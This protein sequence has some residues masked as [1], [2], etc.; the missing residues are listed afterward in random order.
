MFDLNLTGF[1]GD[2]MGLFHNGPG[3][4]ATKRPSSLSSVASLNSPVYAAVPVKDAKV[5]DKFLRRVGRRP[6]PP[7]PPARGRRLLPLE[8][9]FYKVPLPGSDQRIRCYGVS[10]GRGEVAGVLRPHGHGLYLA[11]KRCILGR[12][13]GAEGPAGRPAGRRPMPW[14]A[15][16]PT[17]GTRCCPTTAWAGKKTAGRPAWGTWGRFP[18]S[19]RAMTAGGTSPRT[20]AAVLRE[21]ERLYADALLLSRRRQLRGLGR[22]QGGD[23]QRARFGGVAQAT[24][25]T[26]G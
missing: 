22:R 5:V 14:S 16:A 18:T 8:H 24:G 21:A 4:W 6:G 9:D 23:V 13:P 26:D 7:R 10:V 17:T 20:P 1:L 2:L 25:G 15:S 12:P 3:A 19:A 11:S